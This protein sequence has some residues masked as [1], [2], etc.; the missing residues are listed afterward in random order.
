MAR[1][2]RQGDLVMVNTGNDRGKTGHVLR[3][4]PK[5]EQVYVEGMN[6]R[7]KHVRPTQQNPQGGRIDK[8]MPIHISNVQPVSPSSGKATRVRFEVKP[9][10]SKVRLAA[11]GGDMLSTLRKARN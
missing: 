4:D 10:G 8:E 11:A 1:H 9:D 5:K 6:V 2:V 7:K 3:V